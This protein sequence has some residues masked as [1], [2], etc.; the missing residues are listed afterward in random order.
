MSL[1]PDLRRYDRLGIDTETTGLDRHGH[2]VGLSVATPRG[3]TFYFSWGAGDP[4]GKAGP[5]EINNCSLAD[6]RA[7]AKDQLT[8]HDVT[9]HAHN[10]LFDT[11]MLSVADIPARPLECTQIAATLLDEHRASFQLNE[12]AR[13]LD[14]GTKNDQELLDYCA[15]TFGGKPTRKEQGQHF[16]RVPVSIMGPYAQHDPWLTLQA[17]DKLR[18]LIT[19]H[20]L[21]RVYRL[22]NDI[23]PVLVRMFVHGVRVDRQKAV[24]LKDRL[25]REALELVERWKGEY[26]N[27]NLNSSKQLG[28]LFDDLAIP[29]PRTKKTGAPSITKDYLEGLNHPIGKMLRRMRQ[30]KHY[31]NTFVKGYILD[32][33]TDDDEILHPEFHALKGDRYGARGGRFSSGGDLNA[34]N[35]PARDEEW[36][37]LIRGLFRPMRDSQ[38]WLCIDYSQIEYRLFAHYAGLLARLRHTESPM[39]S[40]YVANPRIDFHQWVSDTAGIPRKRAKN[41]NFCKLYG[42]GIAKIALTAGC[43]FEEAKEFVGEYERK[44]PEAKSLMDDVIAKAERR[45]Y[46]RTF[47]GRYCRFLTEGQL[48]TRMN[49]QPEGGVRARGRYVKIYSALN[50]ILQGSAAD[51]I[52]L[53]MIEVDKAIDWEQ[54][55]LHLTVHDELDLSTERDGAEEQRDLLV[56]IMQDTVRTPMWNG[57]HM[58][59]PIIAEPGLGPDWG[60]AK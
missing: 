44:I 27:V 29:Y 49:H 15:R 3:E 59:V 43:S 13:Q 45:G 46:V 40:A 17:H 2:P 54:T 22:E 41:V 16:W 39:E 32:N 36:A 47:L 58:R 24:R 18:P 11:R 25:D 12:I 8:R 31:A 1:F 7:W 5:T 33:T 20:G 21:D 38:V 23:V 51:L 37:P 26:G 57:E 52:K 14:L 19:A 35:M 4:Y 28:K 55:I 9:L 6:V 53:A 42:G 60:A 10:S 30:L 56:T 50:K 34:Q 48:A